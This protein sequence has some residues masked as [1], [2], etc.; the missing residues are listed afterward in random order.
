VHWRD[1]WESLKS[2]CVTGGMVETKTEIQGGRTVWE[3]YV[4]QGKQPRRGE[5][6]GD[7]KPAES[8]GRKMPGVYGL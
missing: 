1:R 4:G 5:V 7:R 2:P 8:S 3:G 6:E